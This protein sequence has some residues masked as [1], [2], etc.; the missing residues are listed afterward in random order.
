M[1]VGAT[2]ALPGEV[3]DLPCLSIPRSGGGIA[4]LFS[5]DPGARLI[6]PFFDA[7]PRPSSPLA[8]SGH[9]GE[10]ALHHRGHPLRGDRAASANEWSL[11]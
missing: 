6:G 4:T 11:A 5:L 9:G 1:L 2:R 8:Q 7:L 10:P 3:A